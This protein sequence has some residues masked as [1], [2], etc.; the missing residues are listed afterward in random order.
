MQPKQED[1]EKK[2]GKTTIIT[3]VVAKK[4]DPE[5]IKGERME[6]DADHMEV[7]ACMSILYMRRL[8]VDLVW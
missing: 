7:C 5:K 6:N 4:S 2:S 3:A 1:G 8:A